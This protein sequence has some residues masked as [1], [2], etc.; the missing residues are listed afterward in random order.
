[1][2]RSTVIRIAVGLAVAVAMV[3]MGACGAGS[4][5]V[6]KAVYDDHALLNKIRA[7]NDQQLINAAQQVD[8][9]QK[10]Q[11]QGAPAAK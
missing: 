10:Q 1:M 4:V 8:Q 6:A 5:Y 3:V 11:A 9:F 2:S 7:A